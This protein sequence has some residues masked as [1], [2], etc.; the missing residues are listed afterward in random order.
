MRLY[1]RKFTNRFIQKKLRPTTETKDA[2][3]FE[4]DWNKYLCKCKIQGSDE[5]INAHFPRNE[6]TIPSW[7]KAGNA[8]RILHRKGVRGHTEVIG[9][10]GAIP[11]P[12]QGSPSH[13]SISSLADAVISGCAVTA[14]GA[15]TIS[16]SSGT[17]RIGGATYTIAGNETG[18]PVMS[19]TTPLMTILETYPPADMGDPAGVNY[20]LMDESDPPMT[21]SE[22]FP[23]EI[24]GIGSGIFVIDLC[25]PNSAGRFRYD[26]FAVGTDGIIDYIKG[27]EAVGQP[28]KPSIPANHV[29]LGEYVLVI[30]G[31]TSINDGNIG[32]EWTSQH[33][34]S[35]SLSYTDELYWDGGDDYPEIGITAKILNQYGYQYGDPRTYKMTMVVGTGQIWGPVTGYHADTVVEQSS[36]GSVAFKYQRDQTLAGGLDCPV[37]ETS[38]SLRFEIFGSDPD[39][40][41]YEAFAKI[42][43]YSKDG[44]EIPFSGSVNV[45]LGYNVV[46]PDVSGDVD[47]DWED[48][49]NVHTTLDQDIEATF[50]GASDG[51]KLVW[52]IRQDSTGGWEVTFPS[53]MKYGDQITAV[54]VN[55]SVAANSRT[56]LG[57]I[58]DAK[59][60]SYDLVA[61]V[62]GYV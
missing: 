8:V 53:N 34:S 10:G 46:N 13:P 56:Y 61:N 21:M 31:Q 28:T 44:F 54:N 14:S 59:T 37:C 30:G 62:S 15:M 25:S 32:W 55:V 57:F 38:P 36:S 6:A 41:F 9:H 58:Y 17:V 50:T 2:I 20:T 22:T 45:Y 40:A 5:Y 12:Q 3:I 19:E 16:I 27:A 43:L 23:P 42:Q 33:A 26:T 29:Q 18:Y 48:A 7:M 4:V 11:T 35:L 60:S 52:L 51:D 24:I 49:K 1:G 39:I 47:I